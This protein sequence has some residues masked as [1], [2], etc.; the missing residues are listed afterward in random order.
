[1]KTIMRNMIQMISLLMLTGFLATLG[2]MTP[3]EIM[4]L[5]DEQRSPDTARSRMTMRIFR[6]LNTEEYDREIRIITYARGTE[7]SHMEF[8]TPRNI[9]GLRVLDL[10]GVIRVFFPS[11]GRVRNI[12]S[13][14]RG[15]SVGGVGGDFSYEDM[16]GSG[17]ITDYHNFEFVSESAEN[18][19]ISG[20]PKDKDSQYSRLVFHIDKKLYIPVQIDYFDGSKQVKQLTASDIQMI[21]DRNVATHLIMKNYERNSRTEIRLTDV[22]WNVDLNDDL[23][24]PN[25]FYR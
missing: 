7:E 17:F 3:Y 20:V 16:G 5:V 1:M 18:W 4:E 23:F 6:T 2:A 15:G 9:R 21:D 22:E 12:G 13:S 19:Q 14:D 8:V 24:H 10:A 11:T 25:R